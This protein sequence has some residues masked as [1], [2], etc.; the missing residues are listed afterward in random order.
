MKIAYIYEY[1]ASN[2]G[3][4]SSRPFSIWQELR[5]RF[6]VVEFFPIFNLSRLLLI[7]KKI[8][9]ALKD[10]R[11]RLER[12]W[13]SLKEYSWRAGR[14]LRREKVDVVFSPSQLTITYLQT[15]AKIIYC[16]DAPFG[17]IANQYPNFTKL[18]ETYLRQGY[19]QEYLSHRNADRIVYPSAWARESAIRLHHADP[20]KCLEQP[21]GANL[22]Y[23]PSWKEVKAAASRR[24]GRSEVTLIM[25]SSDWERKGGSFAV[26]V[27]RKL[28]L[29]GI[30]ARLKVIGAGPVDRI[31][32]VVSLGWVNK[33][34][35]SGARIFRTAMFDSDFIIMPSLA[36]AYGMALWE[37]AAHGLP[38][39]GRAVGGVPS[40]IRHGEN[41][42][43]F[44]FEASATL[45]A[46][47]IEESFDSSI[48]RR[49]SE[50]AFNDYQT[51]GNWRSFVDGVFGL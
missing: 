19:R 10:R 24:A 48:Y 16:N 6:E 36:E 23:R 49:L 25:I 18:S 50:S 8:P 1:D 31:S 38:M 27:V 40:I 34:T 42:L 37:G 17:A 44:P 45:V 15:S 7:P 20:Q 14:F 11:H 41:G 21:F 13:L 3:T 26:D 30:H 5:H 46:S 4:Q 29:R 22:P 39:I 35:E 33:W 28:K 32:E 9:Y 43:L 47:W 2:P 51:R 12:E